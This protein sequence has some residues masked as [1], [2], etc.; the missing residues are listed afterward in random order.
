MAALPPVLRSGYATEGARAVIDDAFTRLGLQSLVS[1]TAEWNAS[2]RR[3]MEKVGMIHD[4]GATRHPPSR[5]I[6]SLRRMLSPYRPLPLAGLEHGQPEVADW[7]R[8]R[9]DVAC[10]A[11]VAASRMAGRS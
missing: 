2:S 10:P 8:R 1:F 7:G 4:A 6:T 9:S 3:V 11:K 5:P